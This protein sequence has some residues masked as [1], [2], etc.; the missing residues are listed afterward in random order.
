MAE[1]VA[2]VLASRP[3]GGAHGLLVARSGGMAR[4]VARAV[5]RRRPGVG[6]LV[7]LPVGERLHPPPAHV[8]VLDADPRRLLSAA[9]SAR[10]RFQ[11]DAADP[12]GELPGACRPFDVVVVVDVLDAGLDSEVLAWLRLMAAATCGGWVIAARPAE[13]APRAARWLRW[14]ASSP[15]PSDGRRTGAHWRKLVREAGVRGTRWRE[16]P[17]GGLLIVSR[18]VDSPPPKS[19]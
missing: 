15:P 17:A 16:A 5:A 19:P 7:A 4:D 14:L 18:E 11:S 6:W 9:A 3:S 8:H 10:Q 13:P 12:A 1:A 2:W